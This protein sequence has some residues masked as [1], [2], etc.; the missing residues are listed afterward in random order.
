MDIT[1]HIKGKFVKK[2]M[3]S[4]QSSAKPNNGKKRP[5]NIKEGSSQESKLKVFVP[6]TPAKSNYKHCDKP[7]H[8]ADE[9]YMNFVVFGHKGAPLQKGGIYPLFHKSRNWYENDSSPLFIS[10]V[11]LHEAI[12]LR[13]RHRLPPDLKLSTSPAKNFLRVSPSTTLP[14]LQN[15]FLLD[16]MASLTVSG[17]VGGYGAAFLIAKEQ[18]RFASVKAKLCGPKAVDLADLEKN[19][20]GSLVEALQR[21]KWTKIATLSDGRVEEFLAA[22]EQEIIHTKSFFFPVESVATCTDGHLEVDQ[23]FHMTYK[24]CSGRALVSTLL[25]LVST[26]CPSTAQKVFWEVNGVWS[27][28]GAV[29]GETILGEAEDDLEPVAEAA[30][31]SEAAVPAVAEEASSRRIED[32][33]PEDIEPIGQFSEVLLPSSQGEPVAHEPSLEKSVAEVPTEDVVMEEAPR[34]QEQVQ[35]QEDVEMEDAPIE[36]EQSVT[37]EF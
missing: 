21:L 5:F 2:E 32:I 11:F 26:H 15:L 17:S 23:R 7:G 18:S 3:T 1:D 24:F 14:D 34:Q 16:S 4:G 36:A 22:G 6:N 19:G 9:C 31:V 25:G 8:I 20:M 30:V 37:K 13:P 27:K 29:E 35:V 33:P 10:F 28:T 12:T